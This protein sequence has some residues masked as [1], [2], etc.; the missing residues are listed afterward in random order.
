[1][2]RVPRRQS[3]LPGPADRQGAPARGA[4]AA[5]PAGR[6][7]CRRT[8]RHGPQLLRPARALRRAPPGL[9]LQGE[10]LA[11]PAPPGLPPDPITTAERASP[12]GLLVAPLRSR[13]AG[14]AV[15]G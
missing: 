11:H 3:R 7:P 9:R 2:G 6:L 15:V 1:P 10:A 8:S 12:A 5:P 14:A 4:R 13:R